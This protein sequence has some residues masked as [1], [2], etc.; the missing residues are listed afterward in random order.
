MSAA[1]VLAVCMILIGSPRSFA[2][3]RPLPEDAQALLRALQDKSVP[4]RR[5]A[6]RTLSKRY[7]TLDLGKQELPAL[8]AALSDKDVLVRRNAAMTLA[9]LASMVHI[10]TRTGTGMAY[11]RTVTLD[12]SSDPPLRKALSRGLSDRDA[13]IREYSAAALGMGFGPDPEIEKALLSR[14]KA[15]KAETVRR[16]ILG[17]LEKAG[18]DSPK[19]RAAV[20]SALSSKDPITRRRAEQA[21]ERLGSRFADR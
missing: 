8:R 4:A 15:E 5:E 20:Q 17:A 7:R 19:A 2:G 6:A 11:G 1:P 14:W 18:Y 13:D 21:L 10:A 16:G 12:L 3:E 9:G